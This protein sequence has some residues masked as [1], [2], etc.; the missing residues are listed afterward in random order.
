MKRAA[1]LFRLAVPWLAGA[2]LAWGAW[3]LLGA[4]TTVRAPLQWAAT[5]LGPL[6]GLT[7]LVA[8]AATATGARLVRWL[9]DGVRRDGFWGLAFAMGMLAFALAV[10]VV[11]LLGALGPVMFW[12]LPLGLLALGWRALVE[13]AVAAR[14]RLVESP[15]AGLSGWELA[16]GAFGV[17]ALFVALLPLVTPENTNFD[18]RWYH[19]GIAQKYAVTGAIRPSAIGDVTYTGPHLASWLYAWA[20]TFEG[21]AYDKVVLATGVEALCLL[22]SAALVPATMRALMPSLPPRVSRLAWVAVFAFPSLYIYD[23]GLEG[24]ADHVAA[25][26]VAPALLAW[27]QARERDDARSWALFAVNL[28]ALLLAKYTAIIAVAPLAAAVAIERAVVLVRAR[29]RVPRP[30]LAPFLRSAAL[31]LSLGAALT[32]PYWLRNWLWYGNPTYPVF[33]GLFPSRP[34]NVDAEAW[35]QRYMLE[36]FPPVG[37]AAVRA[38]ASVRALWDHHLATYTWA[39]FTGGTPVFGSL[40]VLTLLALPFVRGGAR[41][42]VLAGL[43]GAGVLT[44]YNLSHQMRYLTLFV[45]VMAA[46]TAAM[47]VAIWRLGHPA[48]RLGLAALVAVQFVGAADIPFLPT[49][50]TNGKD[51]PFTR[52]AAWLGRGYKEN[53]LDRFRPFRGWDEISEKLPPRARV[54]LHGN[55]LHIGLWRE[56]MGDAPGVQ[57]GVNYGRLGSLPAVWRRLREVGVTHVAHGGAPLASDSVA[58]ALLFNGLVA[59]P[60]TARVAMHGWVIDELPTSPPPDRSNAV[61]YF[62][63]KGSYA[64]GL[65]AMAD[66]A[67]PMPPGYHGWTYPG[68]RATTAVA[69]DLVPRATWGAVEQG[70]AAPPSFAGFAQIGRIDVPG[71]E[72]TLWLRTGG[73]TPRLDDAAPATAR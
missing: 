19:L 5:R 68:P 65:Y 70:C 71:G 43:L 16:L 30:P 29:R 35:Y 26:W 58:G 7:A 49:H 59:R 14:R 51:A 6:L 15:S 21:D 28:S 44:W 61:L 39:D 63:C 33:S 67:L 50:R 9:S 12:L 73:D 69:Q 23:T 54:L 57:Y 55:A 52:A 66:L 31:V 13:E 2:V 10:F 3:E 1:L 18:A 40:Y 34:W 60:S 27:F 32:T 41:L 11:G 47:V 20:F 72:A 62:G 46:A 48:P 36:S 22:G 42:W 8:L 53:N 17:L 56:A 45:P 25:L 4:F 24:G 37:S 64:T 38:A